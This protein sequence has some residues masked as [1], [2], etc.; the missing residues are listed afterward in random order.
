MGGSGSRVIIDYETAS[1]K[2][3]STDLARF[4]AGFGRLS[5]G[6]VTATAR[7]NLRTF[8]EGFLGG[9]VPN[10]PDLLQDAIFQAFDTTDDRS[11]SWEEF[12]CGLC[13]LKCGSEEQRL[14][15]LFYVYDM[16]R[17]NKITRAELNPFLKELGNGVDPNS[18]RSNVETLRAAFSQNGKASE[19]SMEDFMNWAHRNRT[20]PLVKWIYEIQSKLLAAG[21]EVGEQ[22]RLSR[23]TLPKNLMAQASGVSEKTVEDLTQVFEQLKNRSRLRVVDEATMAT[24]FS[25]DDSA[26]FGLSRALLSKLFVL[27]D[28]TGS[29]S[30]NLDEFVSGLA[31]CCEGSFDA[32][33]SF[34]FKVF[35]S[36]RDGA[37][38]KT[39]FS[40]MQQC[41]KT[42][43]DAASEME[44]TLHRTYAE[45]Q[46]SLSEDQFLLWLREHPGTIAFIDTV[47]EVVCMELGIKPR[48]PA[49]EAATIAHA[50]PAFDPQNIT[51]KPGETLYLISAKW[52]AAWESYTA[53]AAASPAPSSPATPPDGSTRPRSLSRTGSHPQLPPKLDN[54]ELVADSE[55]RLQP[56]LM[57]TEHYQVVNARAWN[58]LHWWYGGGPEIKRTVILAP[59]ASLPELE[60]YP[61][62]VSVFRASSMGAVVGRGSPMSVGKLT[63]FK[64]LQVDV[65]EHMG[66][67][68]ELKGGNVQL[69][70]MPHDEERAAWQLLSLEDDENANV[71]ELGLLDRT[72]VLL[73]ARQ[74]SGKWPSSH[75]K[76]A[77]TSSTNA[78]PV[79]PASDHD[80]GVVG[81]RN[82][83]NTCYMNSALQCLS[84]TRSLREYFLSR[85]FEYDV[86]T[87]AK[88]GMSGHLA[89]SFSE[90]L[91]ELWLTRTRVCS[92]RGFK[93]TIG[94][95]NPLFEGTQ[96]QDAQELLG[97]FME[98]L[99]EDLNRI[100]QKP[101]VELPDSDGRPDAVVA[102]EW[103]ACNMK[104]DLSV[105]TLLFSGQ[106]KSY[107]RCND[108]KFESARF[109]P[110][111]SLQ[112]ELPTP[113]TSYID[114]VI[115][116]ADR[117]QV[118]LKACV[119]V[120]KQGTVWHI[121]AAIHELQIRT[122]PALGDDS[123]V[124]RGDELVV[125][126]VTRNSV[127]ALHEL[128]GPVTQLPASSVYVYQVSPLAAGEHSA[129]QLSPLHDGVMP[130]DAPDAELGA[131]AEEDCTPCSV[132]LTIVHR[133]QKE[134]QRYWLEPTYPALFG[135]PFVLRVGTGALTGTELYRLVWRQCMH[136]VP[137]YD[138]VELDTPWP[139]TLARTNRSGT[140]WGHWLAGKSGELVPATDDFFPEFD[141]DIE[142]LAV[143]WD[144]RVYNEFYNNTSTGWFEMHD[145]IAECRA[146]ESQPIRLSECIK[147]FTASETV[148]AYCP[149]CTKD[150]DGEYTETPQHKQL[151]PYK[152]P[153][154]LV[155]QLKRFKT[156]GH[157][158]QKLTTLVEFP[159][160]GLDL[161]DFMAQEN[162]EPDSPTLRA[163]N[164]KLS[165]CP[166]GVD[167]EQVPCYLSRENTVY[168]L[169]GVINH[170]GVLGGGHYY[171]FIKSDGVWRCFN[172]DLVTSVD[173]S[174][175]V[176]RNA[177]ILFYQRRDMESLEGRIMP[178]SN[179]VPVDVKAVKRTKWDRPERPK[180]AGDN[181]KVGG[182]MVM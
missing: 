131:S 149:K 136:M 69:W 113:L 55:G 58:A 70:F 148:T 142:T 7:L 128:T 116:F 21:Q 36:D 10:M 172:D 95:F 114:L 5:Q 101:Y 104:R 168:D 162:I 74:P 25:P 154:V 22:K 176:S 20:A 44:A 112:V 180:D 80:A 2:L 139:F 42:P 178:A 102:A 64:Q 61:I 71:Q 16:D 6:R 28:R 105:V 161:M 86:N 145:S 46:E 77:A 177:Y 125:A 11:V 98:G 76:H 75:W 171:A 107:L 175:L 109:D 173:Q 160:D 48:D 60:L 90:L 12:V 165:R 73:E 91:A 163:V 151:A 4:R 18:G 167:G 106:F 94:R 83:G 147:T 164:T 14:R 13:V 23:R 9:T 15:M 32:K 67:H 182:C 92:P 51:F 146:K 31:V 82:L 93:E 157:M 52:W 158:R 99:S 56:N 121:C 19:L 144:M 108:C 66:M 37:I 137:E 40:Q 97:I 38:S 3:G 111:S 96:Q 35:D 57:H 124:L 87:T 122:H 34:A 39:E 118:P 169:Y 153:P 117:S 126:D 41:L 119:Q 81:L 179:G 79:T 155:M 150:H 88:Y 72:L 159:I 152:V 89:V 129:W 33:L 85:D 62:V 63:D 27:L 8:R 84:H 138:P 43:S 120:P 29:A 50:S 103:W 170:E 45:D 26:G 133:K 53:A 1:R 115:A 130:E 65:C 166:T 17:D 78:T 181:G 132:V 54:S 30:I 68:H 100:K 59:E 174:A 110:F 127:W 135:V 134:L 156:Q 140:Q 24:V 123:P 47:W 49:R 143:D 141:A